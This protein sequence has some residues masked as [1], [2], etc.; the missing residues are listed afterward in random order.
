MARRSPEASARVFQS[1]AVIMFPTNKMTPRMCRS[2]RNRSIVSFLK[3]R[4]FCKVAD[5]HPHPRP[6][7]QRERAGVREKRLLNLTSLKELEKTPA[8]KNRNG[9]SRWFLPARAAAT[10]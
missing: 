1:A 5:A 8:D 3:P 10:G 4:D 9:R 7:S 6:L 2:F